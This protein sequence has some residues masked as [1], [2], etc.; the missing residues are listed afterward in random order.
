MLLAGIQWLITDRLWRQ[1]VHL[2]DL[3]E[4]LLD[5]GISDAT[6]S[7][8]SAGFFDKELHELIDHFQQIP[9]RTENHDRTAGRQIR[10]RAGSVEGRRPKPLVPPTRFWMIDP[11]C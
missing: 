7:T 1:L 6:R 11:R 5:Q 4:T 2:H 3:V 8:V 9:L 10:D